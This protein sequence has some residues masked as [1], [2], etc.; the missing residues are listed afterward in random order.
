ML[1][2]AVFGREAVVAKFKAQQEDGMSMSNPT[3]ALMAATVFVHEN[4]RRK[5]TARGNAL[6][7][8]CLPSSFFRPRQAPEEAL[9][10]LHAVETVEGMAMYIQI[11]LQLHRLDL[12]K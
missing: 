7:I 1:T 8:P 12:A 11:L 4:V 3:V 9:R 5:G 2:L 10:C 6:Y